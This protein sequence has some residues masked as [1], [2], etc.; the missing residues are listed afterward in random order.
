M[1]LFAV[2]PTPDWVRTAQVAFGVLLAGWAAYKATSML[3]RTA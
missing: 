3:R 2:E 1:V